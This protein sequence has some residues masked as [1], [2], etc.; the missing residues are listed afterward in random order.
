M[1]ER[2]AQAPSPGKEKNAIILKISILIFFSFSQKP[3]SKPGLKKLTAAYEKDVRGIFSGLLSPDS[4]EVVRR[5]VAFLWFYSSVHVQPRAYVAPAIGAFAMAMVERVYSIKGRVQIYADAP[6]KYGV[7]V[8]TELQTFIHPLEKH[9][10]LRDQYLA[11]RGNP[12]M[13]I[14]FYSITHHFFTFFFFFFFTVQGTFS[15]DVIYSSGNHYDLLLKKVRKN[16]CAFPHFVI[17]ESERPLFSLRM[18]M[19]PLNNQ[20]VQT[21]PYDDADMTF[22]PTETMRSYESRTLL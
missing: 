20:K 16:I 2:L 21:L 10:K 3:P 13:P 6:D 4:H 9:K 15:L 8:G 1:V 19:R 11:P 22:V 14:P 17:R 18:F 12:G 5:Y 7:W